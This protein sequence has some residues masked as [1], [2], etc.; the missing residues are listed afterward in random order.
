LREARLAGVSVEG[1]QIS[2]I[3][4]RGLQHGCVVVPPSPHESGKEY[5]WE[6]MSRIDEVPIS[7]PP[8]WLVAMLLARGGR[9]R[10]RQECSAPV[11]PQSFVLGRLFQRRR[12]LGRQFKP[13]CFA[14]RCPTEQHHSRGEPFDTSTVLFAPRPG[15]GDSR[16]VFYCSH[17]SFCTETWR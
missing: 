10:P 14:V 16:G 9:M 5:T 17:S 8:P 6:A 4:V 3:D 13:G 15:S 1:L 7:D 12:M 2:G 11:D